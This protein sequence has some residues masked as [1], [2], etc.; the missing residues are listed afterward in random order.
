M[1]PLHDWQFWI[2]SALAAYGVWV[3]VR[4]FVRRGKSNDASCPSCPS[5]G[6]GAGGGEHRSQR[7]KVALTI[8]R[9][10]L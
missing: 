5:G 4:P 1:M 7:R 6:G 3:L 2:V 8:E 9:K 10:R